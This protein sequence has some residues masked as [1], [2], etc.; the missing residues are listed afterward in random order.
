MYAGLIGIKFYVVVV[1]AVPFILYL[2]RFGSSTPCTSTRT[3]VVSPINTDGSTYT[4]MSHHSL[5]IYIV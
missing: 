5:V 2:E 1:M 4:T 3:V